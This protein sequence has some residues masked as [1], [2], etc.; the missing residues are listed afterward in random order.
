MRALPR[1]INTVDVPLLLRPEIGLVSE[2]L[3]SIAF[4]IPDDDRSPR[5]Q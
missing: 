3:F 4:R 5:T 2:T 1:G